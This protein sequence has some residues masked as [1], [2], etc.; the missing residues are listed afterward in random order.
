MIVPVSESP[1]IWTL[2]YSLGSHTKLLESALN[3]VSLH[4]NNIPQVMYLHVE[5]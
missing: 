1:E 2:K 4:S 3:I 5:F